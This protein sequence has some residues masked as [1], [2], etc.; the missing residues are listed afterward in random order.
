MST[1]CRSVFCPIMLLPIRCSV[2]VMA[3]II[4]PARCSLLW[5]FFSSLSYS[6]SNWFGVKSSKVGMGI[7]AGFCCSELGGM[8]VTVS[9]TEIRACSLL[10]H[11]WFSIKGSELVVLFKFSFKLILFNSFKLSC[12]LNSRVNRVSETDFCHSFT[13]IWGL[14]GVKCKPPKPWPNCLKFAPPG[15]VLTISAETGCRVV[16]VGAVSK[17]EHL[18]WL[19][20]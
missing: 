8:I 9:M 1:Q 5:F 18:N 2:V 11:A 7:S 12:R 13:V 20:L 4:A 19:F 16:Q 14:G 10:L 17:F 3:F 15:R 6:F